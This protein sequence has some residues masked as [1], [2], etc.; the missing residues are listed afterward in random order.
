MV[1]REFRNPPNL[2]TIRR[3][4]RTSRCLQTT[5]SLQIKMWNAFKA[6]PWLKKMLVKRP[7]LKSQKSQVNIKSHHLHSVSLP[8]CKIFISIP[9]KQH[10]SAQLF[11]EWN[12]RFPQIQ[13]LQIL[14]KGQNCQRFLASLLSFPACLQSKCC[15]LPWSPLYRRFSCISPT[16]QSPPPQLS[17]SVRHLTSQSYLTAACSTVCM[18]SR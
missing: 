2:A 6:F 17:H 5:H 4:T 10:L 14:I 8:L 16:T 12:P 13:S 7:W 18:G 15:P 11:P 3:V 1:I 9:E